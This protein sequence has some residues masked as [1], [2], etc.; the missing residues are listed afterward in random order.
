MSDFELRRKLQDLKVERQPQRD[1]WPG[2]AAQL[3]APAWR[4]ARTPRRVMLPWAAAAAVALTVGAGVW[5]ASHLDSLVAS[6]NATPALATHAP[7]DAGQSEQSTQPARPAMLAHEARAMQASFDG[8]IAA[9]GIDARRGPQSPELEAAAREIDAATAQLQSALAQEP[10]AT[11][12][13]ELLKRTQERRV[14]LA[15]LGMRSA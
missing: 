14:A 10:D 3:A 5:L 13:V 1:L 9:S 6:R 4:P 11:Y 7:A 15:K 2:I 12:L 8:A